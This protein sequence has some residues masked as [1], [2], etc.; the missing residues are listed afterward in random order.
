MTWRSSFYN[1]HYR[2][3]EVITWFICI[4]WSYIYVNTC[5]IME[6]IIFGSFFGLSAAAYGLNH[7]AKKT[8]Q[9]RQSVSNVNF[10]RFQRY[11]TCLYLLDTRIRIRYTINS[12]ILVMYK[13]D[14]IKLE[15]TAIVRNKTFLLQKP[16]Y[17]RSLL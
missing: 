12:L 8:D 15:Y 1:F 17:F 16:S 2:F 4:Y 9:Q 3:Y 10:I 6:A 5:F 7:I 13:Y 11:S 14:L